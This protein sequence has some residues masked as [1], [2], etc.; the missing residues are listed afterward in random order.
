MMDHENSHAA[1]WEA[2]K[3]NV[4]PLKRGRATKGLAERVE[5]NNQG[6]EISQENG[7]QENY[8]NILFLKFMVCKIF[9]NFRIC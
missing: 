8:V 2:A 5:F 3:E 6:S 4:L 9:C 1:G 7:F